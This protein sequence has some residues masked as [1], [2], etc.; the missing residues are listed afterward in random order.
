MSKQESVIAGTPFFKEKVKISS[1]SQ[2][3]VKSAFEGEIVHDGQRLAYDVLCKE[4]N[5]VNEE[6]YFSG[7]ANEEKS[8]IFIPTSKGVRLTDLWD[9]VSFWTVVYPSGNKNANPYSCMRLFSRRKSD[10]K[11]MAE[12]FC[13]KLPEKYLRGNV[14]ELGRLASHELARGGALL[15]A[16][17]IKNCLELAMATN[18]SIH[19]YTAQP[20]V[21]HLLSKIKFDDEG[22]T[23]EKYKF[24]YLPEDKV[25]SSY[26]YVVHYL[27]QLN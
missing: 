20:N 21:V 7:S 2:L 1:L 4:T 19:A 6:G 18:S 11:M 16:L 22:V 3:E 8:N 5:I 15:C 24:L 26:E 10:N 13:D 23:Q 14:L 27:K 9:E 17:M 12:L 25:K